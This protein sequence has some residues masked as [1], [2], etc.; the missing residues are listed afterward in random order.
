MSI[1]DYCVSQTHFNGH[2]PGKREKAG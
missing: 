1:L 2:F